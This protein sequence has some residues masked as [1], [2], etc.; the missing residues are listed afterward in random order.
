MNSIV[1]IS[2]CATPNN[3]RAS[4]EMDDEEDQRLHHQK[5]RWFG[6]QLLPKKNQREQKVKRWN[7]L[8]KQKENLNAYK[9]TSNV[10][11][12]ME[13]RYTEE[14]NKNLYIDY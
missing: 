4:K 13:Y 2:N 10:N 5:D 14:E 6:S 8:K 9:S 11:K 1:E 12:H 7:P 3:D